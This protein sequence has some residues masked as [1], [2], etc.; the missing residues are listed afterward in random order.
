MILCCG[1]LA[2]GV[3]TVGRARSGAM[4]K[5]TGR[6]SMGVLG[7]APPAVLGG[8]GYGARQVCSEV[9]RSPELCYILSHVTM[10]S[11]R[12]INITGHTE[13][14]PPL[15]P[16]WVPIFSSSCFE[17]VAALAFGLSFFVVLVRVGYG[18]QDPALFASELGRAKA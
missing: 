12:R 10:L 7:E 9:K 17:A 18:L 2:R 14:N 1:V 8:R 16:L 3:A 5:E 13:K 4:A 15:P 6:A 11:R